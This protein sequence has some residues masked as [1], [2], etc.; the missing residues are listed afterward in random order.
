MLISNIPVSS[1]SPCHFC[2]SLATINHI[3]EGLDINLCR[4]CATAL[5]LAIS[6]EH[7]FITA[8]SDLRSPRGCIQNMR[9]WLKHRACRLPFDTFR[10][11]LADVLEL[12]GAR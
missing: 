2:D 1:V 5:V 12:R 9:E 4:F 6:Q 3:G 8:D 11:L 7:G 10:H